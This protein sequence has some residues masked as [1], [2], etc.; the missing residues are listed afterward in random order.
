MTN[1]DEIR[2]IF[3]RTVMEL[4]I[5]KGLTQEQLAELLD[6]STHTVNRIETG[7]TFVSAE[8]IA[9]LCNIFYVAPNVLFTPKPHILIDE[10][11]DY[12]KKIIKLLPGVKTDRLKDVY[13][14]IV[15]SN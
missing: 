13:N 15:L 9:K 14:F 2:I 10:H 11:A 8:V 6:L 5:Q 4:R 3:G 1:V 12:E 7:K